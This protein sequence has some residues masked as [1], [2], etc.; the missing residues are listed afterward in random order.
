[1]ATP[2]EV[3]LECLQDLGSEDFELFQWYLYQQGVLEDFKSIPKSRLE[4]ANRI[5]TVDLM[6]E[7]YSIK[8]IKVTK[9]ILGKMKQNNLLERLSLLPEPE[10]KSWKD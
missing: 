9:I 5:K 2:T 6:F 8:A 3:L 4:N 1:M 10:G 7:S